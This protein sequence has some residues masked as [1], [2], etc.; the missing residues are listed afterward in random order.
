[1]G[2]PD[3][4]S[5]FA[6]VR[7]NLRHA[8]APVEAPINVAYGGHRTKRTGLPT[9]NVPS[10]RM[11]AFLNEMKTARLRK[12]AGGRPPDLPP[13]TSSSGPRGTAGVDTGSEVRI[14][15]KRKRASMSGAEDIQTI[16]RRLTVAS[17]ADASRRNDM[18]PPDEFFSRSFS[19]RTAYQ[20]QTQ[21]QHEH[22][23]EPD[24]EPELSAGPSTIP[25]SYSHMSS[26]L[27]PARTGSGLSSGSGETTTPSLT[28]DNDVEGDAEDRILSTPPQNNIPNLQPE[29]LGPP[30]QMDFGKGKGKQRAMDSEAPLD[31]DHPLHPN[32]SIISLRQRASTPPSY[33]KVP[34][35][36]P[37]PVSRTPTPEHEAELSMLDFDLPPNTSTTRSPQ[38]IFDKRPPKSPLP[39]RASDSPRKPRP[40]GRIPRAAASPKST[41]N[42]RPSTI[43]K[44]Q[45]FAGNADDD[46]RDD[47]PSTSAKGAPG[48]RD[49]SGWSP[50]LPARSL[51]PQSRIPISVQSTA[52]KGP[53][54]VPITADHPVPAPRKSISLTSLRASTSFRASTSSTKAT[55]PTV[56]DESPEPST[57]SRAS[58]RKSKKERRRTLDEELQQAEDD[59]EAERDELENDDLRLSDLEAPVLVGVGSRSKKRGFMAHGG[60]G[61]VPV[62]MGVGYVDGAVEDEEEAQS[63]ENGQEDEEDEPWDALDDEEETDGE[64]DVKRVVKLGEASSGWTR[65][66]KLDVEGHRRR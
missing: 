49:L 43:S 33:T 7:A 36:D 42:T 48:F 27:W 6:S 11:P 55:R 32:T 4:G 30:I 15:E 5:L 50:P 52:R 31:E 19:G 63:S 16:K 53:Q 65:N 44:D 14:G 23:H 22:E 24:P 46:N 54:R 41:S 62:F 57:S 29:A 10:D 28:S 59:L 40:P 13:L 58:P 47:E 61:G 64:I 25:H 26:N 12:V 37:L 21:S 51:P 39:A 35:P 38:S 34:F 8:P 3:T 60:G 9:V 18:P 20:M 45:H 2:P 17:H 66:L 1:M 56:R